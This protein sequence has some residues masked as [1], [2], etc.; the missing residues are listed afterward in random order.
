MGQR[1]SGPDQKVAIK[2]QKQSLH[3]VWQGVHGWLGYPATVQIP[4]QQQSSEKLFSKS[5]V[6][7]DKQGLG[8]AMEHCK[9]ASLS[10]AQMI[11]FYLS[12]APAQP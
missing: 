12:L 7:Q 11:A 5:R 6:T 4:G 2:R 9:K 10:K 8:Q 3:W 1:L